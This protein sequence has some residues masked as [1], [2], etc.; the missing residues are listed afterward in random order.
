MSCYLCSPVW[1]YLGVYH[2]EDARYAVGY[3]NNS[4]ACSSTD[5]K[6]SGVELM[7][8]AAR[9]MVPCTVQS[10]TRGSGRGGGPAPH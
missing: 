7:V 4:K 8:E 2:T 9:A 10:W 6:N 3:V 1:K 5:G